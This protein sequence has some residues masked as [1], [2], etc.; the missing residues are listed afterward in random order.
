MTHLR[1]LTASLAALLLAA[2]A[3]SAKDYPVN[4]PDST[5]TGTTYQRWVRSVTLA[6]ETAPVH[7]STFTTGE[8]G[9][10]HPL[11]SDLTGAGVFAAAPGSKVKPSVDY[12]GQWMHAYL[13]IDYNNDG[14]F[15]APDS[16][17]TSPGEL[18]SYSY[19]K[20]SN[21]AG[22][23]LTNS[24]ILTMPPF[25]I[26]EGTAPGVYR[27]RFV[28]DWDAVDPGGS[29]SIV[30]NG[31]GII[32]VALVIASSIETAT[33]GSHYDTDSVKILGYDLKPLGTSGKAFECL[34]LN[35]I[36]RPDAHIGSITVT[37]ATDLPASHGNPSQWVFSVD[38]SGFFR[39]NG[40]IPSEY[41]QPMSLTISASAAQGAEEMPYASEGYHLIWNDEFNAPDGSHPS[42]E[43][44]ETPDRLN[45][46]WNRFISS[47]PDL[48][49]MKDGNLMM[50]CKPNPDPTEQ[51]DREMV[52]GA[53]RTRNHFSLKCGRIEA[54]MK[55]HGHWG[56]FPAFWLMPN[57]QPDGWPVSGEIDIFES[58]NNKYTAFGT[59]HTGRQAN[60][61]LSTSAYQFDTDIN[62][63]HVYGLEWDESN[64]R[65]YVDG[66]QR[67]HLTPQNVKQGL[68]PFNE[69]QFYFILNQ[70][71][72]NG[73]WASAPDTSW[74]YQTEVDWV[75]AYQLDGQEA[76]GA[77]TY[78][79]DPWAGLDLP[80]ADKPATGPETL[81]NLQGIAVDRSA[82]APGIYI[83]RSGS[84]ATKILI[85]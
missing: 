16:A 12:S 4:Y 3:A 65:F 22:E 11:Y 53:I 13:Y 23:E 47:R 15:Q 79:A 55:V 84:S 17:L 36:T 33:I 39:G 82:A 67:G 75:R 27:A 80:S 64:L 32:D 69:Q 46:A 10:T 57:T 66:I 2:S 5:S 56:S 76:T 20:G 73:G 62:D 49:V 61:D 19:Y 50:Y 6:S 31:G 9:T 25:T 34:P 41:I 45:A 77:M 59:I 28:V 38:P 24:N 44:Y 48:M 14:S 85:R 54:R 58:I 81:F 60:Q 43:Y 52:S 30:E 29:A 63:W 51:D 37:A 26:P 74:T 71:V 35:V 8:S 40:V 1:P 7:S 70:S 78:A 83:L 68:W 72:G 21:S 18:V 42:P